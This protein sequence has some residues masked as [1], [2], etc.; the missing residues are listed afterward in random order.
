MA[1]KKSLDYTEEDLDAIIS[2]ASYVVDGKR[3]KPL[4]DKDISN[5]DN[6][7]KSSV[8]KFLKY[9]ALEKRGKY[10]LVTDYGHFLANLRMLS[11]MAEASPRYASA[12]KKLCADRKKFVSSGKPG[13]VY[14]WGK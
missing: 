9:G 11:L 14:T 13:I 3:F 7:K 8:T 6:I 5:R 10:Y 1:A 4:T 12:L 2:F